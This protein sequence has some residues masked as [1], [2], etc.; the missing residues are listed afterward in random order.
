MSRVTYNPT[1]MKAQNNVRANLFPKGVKLFILIYF[2]VLLYKCTTKEI[3]KE[4]KMLKNVKIIILVMRAGFEPAFIPPYNLLFGRVRETLVV[5][6]LPIQPSHQMLVFPSC[7]D[8]TL[9]P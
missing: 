8:F 9:P 6:A 4:N 3:Q 1:K 2:N 7:H 5:C